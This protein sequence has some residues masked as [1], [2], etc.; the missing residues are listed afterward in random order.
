MEKRGAQMITVVIFLTILVTY[1]VILATYKPQSKYRNGMLFSIKLP[2]QAMEHPDIRRIQAEYDRRFNRVS[3]VMALLLVPMILLYK[4]TTYQFVYLFAWLTVFFIVM[5]L[6]FRK[7]FRDTLTLKKASEWANQADEDEY[8]ANGFSYHNPKDPRVFVDK[9]VGVGLTVNTGTLAGKLIMGGTVALFAAVV[10]GV[11]VM[12]IRSE[13]DPPVMT[14]TPDA[15][16]EIDYQMYPFDF[17]IA[18]IEELALVEEIPSG[19]RTNGEATDKVARGH[20]NLLD[21]GKARLYVFKNNPP[22]IRIKLPDVYIF[23]N[24]QDPAKTRRLYEDLT[25]RR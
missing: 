3:L 14:I 9:R 13:L 6:P 8:W 11:S 2:A 20:F 17:A 16:V 12:M 18:E 24:E 25:A 10:L 1:I 21:L 4:F 22:Y 15:R 19:R 5:V 7:A 23:Y